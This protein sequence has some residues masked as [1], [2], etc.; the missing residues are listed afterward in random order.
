MIHTEGKWRAEENGYMYITSM[1][2]GYKRYICRIGTTN[3]TTNG[4][5]LTNAE[6]ICQMH[7]S[8][9]GLLKVSKE[10]LE[11]FNHLEVMSDNDTTFI[12][13]SQRQ[14]LESAI[15]QAEGE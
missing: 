3:S 15:A 14:E 12:S 9:D 2:N 1:V 4:E 10:A 13:T 11:Q 5:N 8:F 6:H 7:N